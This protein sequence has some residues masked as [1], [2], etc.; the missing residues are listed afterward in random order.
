[1]YAIKILRGGHT[2]GIAMYT[3][4]I[5]IRSINFLL[6]HTVDVLR[7]GK[8]T[9]GW[10]AVDVLR[11]GKITYGWIPVYVFRWENVTHGSVTVYILRSSAVDASTINRA[12]LR[13]TFRIRVE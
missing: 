1:M 10:I 6:H 12:N 9:H 11:W 3:Q 7:W 5:Y 2:T 4:G 13:H 8:M